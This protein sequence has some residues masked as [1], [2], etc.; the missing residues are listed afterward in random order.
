MSAPERR[1]RGPLVLLGALV[2]IAIAVAV[3]LSG[4]RR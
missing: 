4:P 2:L 3:I 1:V